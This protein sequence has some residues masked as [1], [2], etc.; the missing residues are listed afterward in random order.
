MPSPR[1]LVHRTGPKTNPETGPNHITITWD[2]RADEKNVLLKGYTSEL[3]E[4]RKR[5]I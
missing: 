4:G 2:Y 3:K 5:A 1:C